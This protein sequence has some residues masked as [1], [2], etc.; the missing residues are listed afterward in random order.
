MADG[1]VL[2][3]ST[4][5]VVEVVNRAILQATGVA[6]LLVGAATAVATWG[7]PWLP[8]IVAGDDYRALTMSGVGPAVLIATLAS[9]GVLVVRTR[10]ATRVELCLAISLVLLAMDEAL[11]LM[12]GSRLSVG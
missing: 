3:A 7:L 2:A 4:T 10:C 6:V 8:V 11:T 9:L 1:S 5:H 12:G